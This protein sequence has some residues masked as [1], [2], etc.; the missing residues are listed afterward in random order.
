MRPRGEARVVLNLAQGQQGETD[1]PQAKAPYARLLAGD[2]Q[3]EGKCVAQVTVSHA[4]QLQ[5]PGTE[6]GVVM[7]RRE[8]REI[9]AVAAEHVLR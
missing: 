9:D 2:Q 4:Y 7:F 8:L 3:G 6:A 1:G 5:Q